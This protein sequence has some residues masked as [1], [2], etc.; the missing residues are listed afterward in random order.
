MRRWLNTPSGRGWTLRK[1]PMRKDGPKPEACPHANGLPP[2]VPFLRGLSDVCLA[3]PDNLGGDGAQRLGDVRMA[4]RSSPCGQGSGRAPATCQ[5]IGSRVWCRL[6][7]R[8]RGRK[9][10]SRWAGAGS[11][12][13]AM[14]VPHFFNRPS[15]RVDQA[16]QQQDVLGIDRAVA[17]QV[18]GSKRSCSLSVQPRQ[19]I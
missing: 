8:E 17:V 18:S 7:A 10:L 6:P 4:R 11:V 13:G 12:T 3:C 2:A 16:Q 5:K 15:R 14:S 9:R 1:L 19:K